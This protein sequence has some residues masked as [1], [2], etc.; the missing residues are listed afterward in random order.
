MKR[1]LVSLCVITL[2]RFKNVRIAL[3][4]KIGRNVQIGY[5]TRINNP[6]Y[7]Y[8]CKI[9]RFCAIAGNLIVRSKNHDYSFLNLNEKLQREI[10]PNSLHSIA[11]KS[12]GRVEIADNVW[13][14]DSVILLSGVKIGEGAVIGAGSVVTKN[15][16]AYSVS[17]GVPARVIKYRF[18]SET[19]EKLLKL[20][21]WKMS[22][23]TL[24]K[25]HFLFS[26]DLS[27]IS[28]STLDELIRNVSS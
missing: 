22:I 28:S 3:F 1:L 7:I 19:I 9:G 4:S 2:F 12:K 17:V 25:N 26:E 8:D 6:S 16:P 14:G 23:K 18:S 15:I 10:F 21:L 27:N 5:G 11:N 13:I 20:S 24:K